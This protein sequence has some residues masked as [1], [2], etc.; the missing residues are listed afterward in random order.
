MCIASAAFIAYTSIRD[1]QQRGRTMT[2][3]V[4]GCQPRRV[5]VEVVGA[6]GIPDVLGGVEAH[7]EQLLPRLAALAPDLDIEIV[8]RPAYV[9]GGGRDFRGVRVK[10]LYAPRR[11]GAE[12]IVSAL[13]GVMRARR[14]G[15]RLVHFHGVGPALAAPLA[16][17]LGMR[18]IVTHH[19][20]NYDHAKWG[21]FARR[22]LRL[23]ERT[24]MRFADRVIA[25]A[26]W[27]D[28]RLRR[29]FQ[30]FAAKV[31]H[32][33]NGRAEFPEAQDG[34][35]L[36]ELGLEP[37]H[38]VL[39]VGRLV[40]E[41]RFDLL[42][43]AIER[44]PAALKL[45]IAGGADHDTEYARDL[46]SRASDRII[47]SGVR[48][49]PALRSLYEHAALFVLSSDHEGLPLAALEASSFGCPILLSD[50]EPNRDLGLPP[51]HYFRAGDAADLGRHLGR[52]PTDYL[53]DPEW[54]ADYDWNRIA[55][56]TLDQYRAVLGG[57]SGR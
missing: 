19:S 15:A 5:A 50:I 3:E 54:G 32:I 56:E 30:A 28:R 39:G 1:E 11:Q 33:P 18:V 20:L 17:S 4:G 37:G 48:D 10:P 27:L 9:R 51:H 46:L 7:C 2:E 8:A 23:G 34:A 42:I 44:S 21:G 29:Q 14:R 25:V 16:R 38:Y 35:V 6:R 12:A 45:V 57:A 52:N 41:K 53:A 40:P 24:A 49:R 47:F 13:L 36:R 26:P 31:V 55:A 43:D 22:M